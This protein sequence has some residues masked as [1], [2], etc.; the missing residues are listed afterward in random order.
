MRRVESNGFEM[1]P[2]S[3][4]GA[5]FYTDGM[6]KNVWIG[7]AIMRKNKDYRTLSLRIF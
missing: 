2:D 1:V 6:N 3:G 7:T 4:G 5:Q